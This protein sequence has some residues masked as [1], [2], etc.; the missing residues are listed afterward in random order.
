ML[1]TKDSSRDLCPLHDNADMLGYYP[2]FGELESPFYSEVVAMRET[3]P[4]GK[5]IE[6][7]A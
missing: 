5:G 3:A 2:R 1:R 7:G 4:L 6:I